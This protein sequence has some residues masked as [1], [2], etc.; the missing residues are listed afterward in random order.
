[1]V[2]FFQTTCGV[3]QIKFYVW[4]NNVYDKKKY[5]NVWKNRNHNFFVR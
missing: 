1:M 4:V 5:V 2:Y 3:I